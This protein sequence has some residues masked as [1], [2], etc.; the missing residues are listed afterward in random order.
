MRLLIITLAAVATALGTSYGLHL[1]FPINTSVEV[2]RNLVTAEEV[3]DRPLKPAPLPSGR[4]LMPADE[5]V[6]DVTPPEQAQLSEDMSAPDADLA[7][8][9]APDDDSDRL[10]ED[11]LRLAA[12]ADAEADAT[13]EVPAVDA[14]N[15]ADQDDPA[16]ASTAESESESES[17]TATETA[18]AAAEPAAEASAPSAETQLAQAKPAPTATPAPSKAPPVPTATA[19][20][21]P[22]PA[23]SASRSPTPEPTRAAVAAPAGPPGGAS[24]LASGKPLTPQV[25]APSSHDIDAR[26]R[27]TAPAPTA[28]PPAPRRPAPRPPPPQTPV[29]DDRE[30]DAWWLRP[31]TP[32]Q[33]GVVHVGTAGFNRAIVLITDGGFNNVESLARNV[34]VLRGGI[35][36]EGQWSLSPANDHLAIFPLVH[37]GDYDITVGAGLQDRNGRVWPHTVR[38]TISVP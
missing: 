15:E 32:S 5:T 20:A 19:T 28:A 25:I 22:K 29:Q 36:I 1:L 3:L 21:T 27:P 10:T 31:T 9:T 35:V 12:L 23:P 34:E 37:A 38:G 30:A 14:A 13:D 11:A 26:S 7:G 4:L 33:L 8:T 17:A 6:I 2:D 18:D 16:E 24:T